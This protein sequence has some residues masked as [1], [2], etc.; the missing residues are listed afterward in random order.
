MGAG[1]LE[2]GV[3]SLGRVAALT[4]AG[5]GTGEEE[6]GGLMTLTMAGGSNKLAG[7]A[8]QKSMV[9]FAA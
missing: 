4:S 5:E 7:V 1:S 2:S 3:W 6:E 9:A 8:G